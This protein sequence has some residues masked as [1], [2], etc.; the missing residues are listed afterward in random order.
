MLDNRPVHPREIF[1]DAIADRTAAV[2][3]VHKHPFGDPNSSEADVRMHG[4]LTKA[5]KILGLSVLDHIIVTRK[6]YYS[7]H[8]ADLIR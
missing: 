7:F 6:G 3:F 8:E 4:Q 1:A 5:G 2:I